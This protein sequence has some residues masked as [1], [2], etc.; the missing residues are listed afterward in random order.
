[1]WRMGCEEPVPDRRSAGRF[2][3]LQE[4]NFTVLRRILE[5]PGGETVEES[6]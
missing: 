4:R 1:M 2:T 5:T 6:G 3:E